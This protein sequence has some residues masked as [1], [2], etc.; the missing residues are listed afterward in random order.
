MAWA[1]SHLAPATTSCRARAATP[2][3]VGLA[4]TRLVA[5]SRK[6]GAAAPRLVARSRRLGAASPRLVAES[7]QLVAG[8]SLVGTNG[9]RRRWLRAWPPDCRQLADRSL[10]DVPDGSG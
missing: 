9:G 8:P 5:R 2:C 3:G 10:A 1:R 7:S 6:L 4:S